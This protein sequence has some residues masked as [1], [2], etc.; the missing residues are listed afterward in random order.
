MNDNLDYAEAFTAVARHLQQATELDA[1]DGLPP[2]HRTA[3]QKIL[4]EIDQVLGVIGH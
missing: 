1:T 2:K 4:K 3:L